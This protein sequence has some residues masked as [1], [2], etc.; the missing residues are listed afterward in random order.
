MHNEQP[1][2]FPTLKANNCLFVDLADQLKHQESGV[3][4][5]LR[6]YNR[7]PTLKHL[8]RLAFSSA[9]AMAKLSW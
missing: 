5:D 7:N 4:V 6:A 3:L 1:E 8:R 9:M 2:E